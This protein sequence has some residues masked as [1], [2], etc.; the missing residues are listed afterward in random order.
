MDPFF[1]PS[2]FDDDMAVMHLSQNLG[3]ETRCRADIDIIAADVERIAR[4]CACYR[5]RYEKDAEKDDKV[6]PRHDRYPYR[7]DANQEV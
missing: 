3:A 4:G 6:S 1:L 7:S 2:N 5:A